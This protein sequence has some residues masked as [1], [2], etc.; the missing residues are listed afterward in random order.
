M[1][2]DKQHFVSLLGK[3]HIILKIAKKEIENWQEKN[4]KETDLKNVGKK[5]KDLRES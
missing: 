1:R 5:K 4:K 3:E 2:K